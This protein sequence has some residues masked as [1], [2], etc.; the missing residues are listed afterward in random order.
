M[1]A[2]LAHVRAADALLART[3]LDTH[4]PCLKRRVRAAQN[5]E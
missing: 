3:P 2:R 5:S 4:R 1:D